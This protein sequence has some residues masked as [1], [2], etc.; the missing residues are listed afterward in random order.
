[1]FYLPKELKKQ[2]VLGVMLHTFHPSTLEL[3]RSRVLETRPV[4][5]ESSR[6]AKTRKEKQRHR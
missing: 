2:N 4:Y 3:G 6:T 5:R 1:M